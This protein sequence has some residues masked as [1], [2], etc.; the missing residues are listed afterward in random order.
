MLQWPF[1]KARQ[2]LD[3]IW[4][5]SES[6]QRGGQAGRQGAGHSV[7][8]VDNCWGYRGDD[9]V[10]LCLLTAGEWELGLGVRLDGVGWMEQ[11]Q[12]YCLQSIPHQLFPLIIYWLVKIYV[13]GPWLDNHEDWSQSFQLACLTRLSSLVSAC[14]SESTDKV[15]FRKSLFC[16]VVSLQQY[17]TGIQDETVQS[18]FWY[19]SFVRLAFS[20]SPQIF[21]SNWAFL[22]VK[23]AF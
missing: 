17:N 3:L 21:T 1:T 16:S 12:V 7:G 11:H 9:V 8:S 14:F 23:S 4:F 10:N 22:T 15:F 6:L 5:L 18:V 20:V 2:L 19:K 13:S